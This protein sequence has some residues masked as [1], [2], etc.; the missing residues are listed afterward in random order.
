MELHCDIRFLGFIR[1]Y[2]VKTSMEVETLDTSDIGAYNK[3]QNM[4]HRE[5]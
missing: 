2:S 5:F 4:F 3:L 1:L